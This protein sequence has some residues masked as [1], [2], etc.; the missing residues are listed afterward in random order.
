VANDFKQ[1]I[2]IAIKSAGDENIR[3]L[4]VSLRDLGTSAELSDEQLSG[5]TNEL[6]KLANAKSASRAVESYKALIATQAELADAVDRAGLKLKFAAEQEAATATVLREKVAALDAAKAAQ[7]E[8]NQQSDK[9]ATGQKAVKAAVSEAA[10]AQKSANAEW[11]SANSTLSEATKNYERASTAQDKLV[12]DSK[13]LAKQIEA[14]GLSTKNLSTAQGDLAKRSTEAERGISDLVNAVRTAKTAEDQLAAT[15][16]ADE[17]EKI[18]R[19][20]R[21]AAAAEA[22]L[23]Q[24]AVNAG[25]AQA[26]ASRLAERRA[27][28]EAAFIAEIKQT[29]ALEKAAARATESLQR[30][31]ELLAQRSNTNSASE[32]KYAESLGTS[33]AKIAAIGAAAIGITSAVGLARNGLS[34]L[35]ETA[36]QFQ[37]LDVQLDSVFGQNSTEALTAIQKFAQETPYQLQQ[38]SESFIKLKAFG[39]DPLDGTFQAI[40][41]QAAKLGGSQET[42]TGITLAL[43]QA[44]AKQK[45]QGEEILQLV[46]R[47]VPVWDLLT[48]ATGKS[49]QELQKLSA[50]GKLGRTEIKLL[51]EEIGKSAEGAS[52]ALAN[53][54]PGQI[55]RLSGQWSEFLNLIANSGVLDYLQEQLANVSAEVERLTATGELQQWAKDIADAIVT[56]AKAIQGVT[57][58]IIDHREAIVALAAAY[59]GFKAVSLIG[60][61]ATAFAGLASRIAASTAA[62]AAGTATTSAMLGPLGLLAAALAFTA[63][64]SFNLVDAMQKVKEVNQEVAD[65]ELELRLSNEHLAAASKEKQKEYAAFADVV[66]EKSSELASKSEADT[67]AY[68][69]QLEGA[70]Q[71]TQ[72]LGNEAIATSD[73][74]G[75]IAAREKLAELRASLADAKDQMDQ[76]RDASASAQ[77]AVKSVGEEAVSQFDDLVSS[78]KSAKEAVD[79]IFKD[80]DL[81]KSSGLIDAAAKIE[82]IGT[83]GTEAA[84]AIRDELRAQILK[85]SDEDFAKFKAAAEKAFG[86]TFNGSENLKRSLAGINLDRLGVDIEQIKT[87]FSSVGRAAIEAFKGA[88]TEVETLGLTAEQRAEAIGQAFDDALGK[89]KTQADFKALGEELVKAF[90]TG[91]LGLD[92]YTARLDEVKAKIAS[93]GKPSAAGSAGGGDAGKQT[94]EKAAGAVANLGDT[95]VETGGKVEAASEG[96]SSAAQAIQNIYSGFANELGKISDAAVQRFTG[97]TRDLFE[98][99]AGIADFS[100]L[101]RFGKAAQDAYDIVTKE[102]D[103]QKIGVAGLADQYANLSD[104]VIESMIRTRG[105]VDRVAGGLD[106]LAQGAR[107]GVS[108]FTLLGQQD[109]SGLASAAQAVAARVRQIG[110]EAIASKRQLADLASS[111]QDQIDQING[112]QTAV[113]NRRFQ[114]DLARI[115]ALREA[116]GNA[117]SSEYSD[118]VAAAERLHALK[119]KQLREQEAAAKKA[120]EASQSN[121]TSTS[122]N[123]SS[124]SSAGSS[125]AGSLTPLVFQF[126]AKTISVQGTPQ[127]GSALAEIIAQLQRAS[128]L[129]G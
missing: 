10:A 73:N 87:G 41:D 111:F 47:G 29:A 81:T 108:E 31:R 68:I 96:I 74:V 4:L 95:A 65:A 56:A 117:N 125:S 63:N 93:I 109:L 14:A 94:F 52:G 11:K 115:E 122:S 28:T 40:A 100:G 123:Q 101:A 48:K 70:I 23:A 37:K 113:E 69:T 42:L 71:Y 84:A 80:L 32:R 82:T 25:R 86:S 121:S 89:A 30:A 85:L 35:L 79:G 98:L 26:E 44:Q 103:K 97:L 54:L 99:S 21:E 92:Q 6:D 36:G 72:A 107:E 106:L 39:L 24:A 118:A 3:S 1:V 127:A 119:L 50:A 34:Q 66:I 16:L 112:N 77:V 124:Q 88:R 43:G 5:L 104:S 18:A 75:K 126:G 17:Q 8:Y 19:T 116:S 12:K 49:V 15:K 9:T 51:I 57:G 90:D 105:G 7:A 60:G 78:G 22:Q 110:E 2:E 13:D 62:M 38:V 128:T 114:N 102:V 76:L 91:Q 129:S 53:T 67:Q 46:E 61:L 58:F 45:L 83:R 64:A 55:N 59:A 27:Q 20:A 33:A 120:N